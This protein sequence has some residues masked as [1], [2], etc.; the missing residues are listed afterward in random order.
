MTMPKVEA[1]PELG[2]DAQKSQPETLALFAGFT[3]EFGGEGFFYGEAAWTNNWWQAPNGRKIKHAPDF[4]HSLDACFKWLV[5]KG[6]T[7]EMGD[8]EHGVYA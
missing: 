6:D 8:H 1:Q 2:S 7:W 4:M 5:P 3:H